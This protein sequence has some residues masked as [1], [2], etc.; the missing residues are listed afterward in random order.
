MLGVLPNRNACSGSKQKHR[1]KMKPVWLRGSTM[2][3]RDIPLQV[4]GSASSQVSS[5]SS[6]LPLVSKN[7]TGAVLLFQ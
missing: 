3:Y 4:S 1:S 7:G 2:A 5:D 6:F